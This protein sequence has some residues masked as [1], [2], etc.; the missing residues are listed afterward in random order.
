MWFLHP[1]AGCPG[2]PIN[3]PQMFGNSHP[4][5]LRQLLE[6]DANSPGPARPIAQALQAARLVPGQARHAGWPGHPHRSGYL[7]YLNGSRHPSWI[8]G[9][10]VMST[11]DYGLV[12]ESSPP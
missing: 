5:R 6:P 2:A 11:K 4:L 10:P 8:F 9:T 1:N 7:N 3:H 12:P